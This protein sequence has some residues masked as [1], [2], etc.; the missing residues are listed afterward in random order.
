M[1][2]IKDYPEIVLSPQQLR[3]ESINVLLTRF[4]FCKHNRLQNNAA[5]KI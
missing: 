2:A 4:H 3:F 1:Q 5:S